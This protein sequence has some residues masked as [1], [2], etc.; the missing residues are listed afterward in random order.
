MGIRQFLF[1][2]QNINQTIAKN[3]FWLSFGEITG[4]LL[5]LAIIIYAARILGAANWGVF[6]YLTS[7][8]AIF[9]VFT[10][11]GLK[12]TLIRE[13]TQRPEI[14]QKYFSTAFLVKLILIAF[15][16]LFIVIGTPLFSRLPM[17][18][19][20]VVFIGLLFIFDSLTSFGSS[21]FRA[22]EKMERE[23]AINITTQVVIVVAGFIGLLVKA[24]PESLAA[25]YA[26]GSG[27]GLALTAYVLRQPVKKLFSGFDK[28]LIRPI[29]AMAWPLGAASIFGIV[30]I[31]VDT[32]MIGWFRGAE[33]VGFYAAA[34]RPITFLYLLPALITGGFFPA[35]TRLARKDDEG[36]RRILEKGVGLII[37]MALPLALGMILEADEIVNLLFGAE[38]TAASGPLRILSLTLITAFPIGMIING[39]AAYNRQRELVR[40]W[41]AGAL[42][43]VGLNLLLIPIWGM[44]GAAWSSFFTQAVINTLIWRRMKKI[45]K[46]SV[47]KSVRPILLATFMMGV[48][49]ILLR[50][51]GLPLLLIIPL[52]AAAYLGSLTWS[53]ETIVTD[54]RR[55]LKQR[56]KTVQ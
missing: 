20:I 21:L 33:E 24:T 46:F 49:V 5:R 36:F 32:I 39:V 11:V 14:K 19:T 50:Q 22:E 44:S 54:F 27:F 18:E 37:F 34:Q 51:V 3:T 16:F 42:A 55:I 40:F 45:N 6:S 26:L 2:N 23:A 7:L 43:D 1:E 25:A 31:N 17:S 15:S 13:I 9:T 53:G 48:V 8:A 56:G 12:T 28:K 30:M 38:Y 4:R 29:L 41:N 47:K 52:A 10:D 35:L